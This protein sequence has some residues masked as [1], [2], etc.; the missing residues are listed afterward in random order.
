VRF[1][2]ASVF[3]HAY[4]KPKRALKPHE[5]EI[6]ESAKSILR[7]IGEGERVLTTTVHFGEVANLLEDLLPLPEALELESGILA[8]DNLEMVEVSK[9]MYLAAAPLAVEKGV[10]LND[11]LAV[12]AMRGRGIS[13]IYSF[14]GD[15]DRLG[16][17]RLSR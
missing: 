12:V 16:V 17:K 7:R 2:D 10:G 3:L 1:V 4:L 6:K 14:D 9:E 11:A 15:F 13:E 5:K 8:L